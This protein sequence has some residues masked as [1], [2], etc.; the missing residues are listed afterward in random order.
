MGPPNRQYGRPQKRRVSAAQN[1][2][3]KAA[4][5][6]TYVPKP[7]VV[8]GKPFIVLEDAEKNTFIFTGGKWAGHERSIADCRKDCQVK[9]LSQKING[10]TRYEICAPVSSH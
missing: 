4:P 9:E 2:A 8:Y 1:A 6:V 3:I 10:M 7:K 5:V